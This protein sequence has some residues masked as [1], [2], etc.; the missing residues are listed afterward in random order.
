MWF[1]MLFSRL[2]S[3]WD[4]WILIEVIE[5]KVS[6]SANKFAWGLVYKFNLRHISILL[7]LNFTIYETWIIF[8]YIWHFH[9]FKWIYSLGGR[10]TPGNSWGV[11]SSSV[12]GVCFQ[13]FSRYYAVLGL[14]IGMLASVIQSIHSVHGAIFLPLKMY[15]VF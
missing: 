7:L 2:F 1:L 12:V 10:G 15:C 4:H 9:L 8:P 6:I 5:Y 3:I 14:E 13:K 11:V